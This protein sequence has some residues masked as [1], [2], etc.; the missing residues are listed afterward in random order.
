MAV[1]CISHSSP[2]PKTLIR[3]FALRNDKD[4]L[5][6]YNIAAGTVINMIL[7]LRGGCN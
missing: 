5:N 7:I 6:K 2:L 3:L 4:T 1:Q